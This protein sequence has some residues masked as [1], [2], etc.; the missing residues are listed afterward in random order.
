MWSRTNSITL[1]RPRVIDGWA[2]ALPNEVVSV[3]VLY[4][5]EDNFKD[6]W[7]NQGDQ[8]RKCPAAACTG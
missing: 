6:Q 4:P 5:E 8:I 7:A 1:G 2:D 3:Q